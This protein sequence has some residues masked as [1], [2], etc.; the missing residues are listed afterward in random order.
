MGD[1][2]ACLRVEFK[3]SVWSKHQD[4]RGAEWVFRGEEDAKMVESSLE[5]CA[6]R[7]TDS[8]VPFLGFANKNPGEPEELC[9]SD[10]RICHPRIK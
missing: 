2:G 3:P 7:T 10:S 4:G 5:L 9:P 6:G 8:A 1:E